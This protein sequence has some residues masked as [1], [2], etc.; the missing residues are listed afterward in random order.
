MKDVTIT[1]N[2]KQYVL[3]DEGE[4]APCDTCALIDNCRHAC[5][6]GIDSDTLEAL[7]LR[8]IQK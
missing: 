8:F 2:E 1:I 3:V 5:I 4:F 6:Y 7:N